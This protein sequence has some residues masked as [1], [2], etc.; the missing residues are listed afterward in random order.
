MRACYNNEIFKKD[1][2]LFM[3]W[4]AQCYKDVSSFQG[5]K[6]LK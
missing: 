1:N 2:N 6:H 3:L 4:K 5:N